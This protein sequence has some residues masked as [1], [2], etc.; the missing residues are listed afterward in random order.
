[1]LWGAPHLL[2]LDLV[3]DLPEDVADVPPRLL[4][5]PPDPVQTVEAGRVELAD[6]AVG[7][8]SVIAAADP[9]TFSRCF[10]SDGER[11]SAK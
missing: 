6:L 8:T 1:M 10:N 2:G 9:F 3:L 4:A 11:A 5:G 7:E